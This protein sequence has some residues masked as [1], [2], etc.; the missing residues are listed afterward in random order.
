M[1]ITLKWMEMCLSI[2]DKKGKSTMYKGS[3]FDP[4]TEDLGG[5]K[6]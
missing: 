6:F 3:Y 4:L 1:E 5:L 2:V